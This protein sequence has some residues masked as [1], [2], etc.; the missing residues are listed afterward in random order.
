MN[1]KSESKRVKTC[2]FTYS[3]GEVKLNTLLQM[4]SVCTFKHVL[5]V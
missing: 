3:V 1:K 2:K 4:E 5:I